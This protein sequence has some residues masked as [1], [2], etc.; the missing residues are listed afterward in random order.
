VTEAS[1]EE[2]DANVVEELHAAGRVAAFDDSVSAAL[3]TLAA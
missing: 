1:R 2:L 3:E